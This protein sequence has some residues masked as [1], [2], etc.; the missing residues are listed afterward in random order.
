MFDSVQLAQVPRA[1]AGGALAPDLGDLW[2]EIVADIDGADLSDAELVDQLASME[3]LTSAAAAAKARLTAELHARRRD[4]LATEGLPA[5]RCRRGVAHE[6]ALARSAS[7]HAGREYL[8]LA[9]ALVEDMPDTLAALARGETSEYRAML[10]VR[11]T[12]HLSR[13]DRM[14]VDATLGPQLSG[15]GNREVVVAARRLA[16]EVD[17]ENAEQRARRARTRRRVTCRGLG[18]GMARVSGDLPAADAVAVMQS[19]GEYAGVRRASGDD[20][21]RDQVMA[22]AFVDRLVRPALTGAR[23]VE[24]QLV[25]NAAMLL[26]DDQETPAHLVGYGPLPYGIAAELLADADGDVFVRRLF[27]NP[28]DNGLVAMDSKRITFQGNLR[29][30]LFTRDGETCRTPWCNAPLRHGDHVT[31]RA[32][33]ARTTLD[34]GQGLCEACNYAKETPGWRHR[35][36]SQWPG[37]HT[38]D[39]TTPTGHTHRSHAPPLPVDPSPAPQRPIVVEIYRSNV[40]LVV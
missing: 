38:T 33:G 35:T 13:D 29:R 34:E 23:N 19:L 24:V 2:T 20:R 40:E 15:L 8:A 17:A 3:R 28:V 26:G 18:D 9:V 1:V 4:R 31:P 7:P 37:R 21:S 39:I 6:V 25:M 27:A 30:L 11:E 5:E 36:R 12:A 10:I 22:D 14:T 16:Y 32:R